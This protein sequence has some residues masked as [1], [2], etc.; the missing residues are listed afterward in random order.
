MSKTENKNIYQRLRDIMLD[1]KAINKESKKINGQYTY[2][3]HDSVAKALHDPMAKAGVVM[4]PTI[5]ELSQDG[6]RTAAKV[7]ISFVNVDNP[8]D[9][10]TVTYWGYGIDGQD[11]GIGKAVSYAVKY[12]LLKTFCLETGDD[13]EKDNIEHKKQDARDEVMK[14]KITQ[15]QWEQLEN[16]LAENLDLRQRMLS[17]L[18][19][20]GIESLQDLPEALYPMYLKSAKEAYEEKLKENQEKTA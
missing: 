10:L 20:K 15:E 6:N 1:V 8:Q 17:H 16:Y 7:D 9:Q 2:V 3:S 14:K 18:K 19:T 13:V 12:C 5:A 4:I 11:K